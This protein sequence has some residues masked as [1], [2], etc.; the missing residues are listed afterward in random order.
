MSLTPED[1][2]AGPVVLDASAIINL[3]GCGAAERVLRSLGYACIVEE[4]VLAE[5]VYHPVPG[6]DHAHEVEALLAAGLLSMHRMSDSEYN[7]YLGLT[8]VGGVGGLG[9]GESA[10]IAVASQRQL[11]VVLDD[12]KARRL[13]STRMPGLAVVSTL[14]LFVAAAYRA[15][16]PFEELT[17]VTRTAQLT[18]CMCVLKDER[19]LV[20]RL[21]LT[22]TGVTA[23]LPR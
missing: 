5:I 23:Q 10:A 12:R 3:L 15:G 19:D 17:K 6:A 16:W 1:D 21:N 18:S 4:R 8:S 2:F 7:V 11:A 13:C 14:K 9:V 20:A 22:S